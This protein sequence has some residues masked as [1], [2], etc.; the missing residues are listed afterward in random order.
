MTKPKQLLVCGILLICSVTAMAN[1]DSLFTMSE[2][3]AFDAWQHYAD[4][5]NATFEW[6]TGTVD[7]LDGIATLEV[8]EGFQYLN[9]EQS[10]FVMSELWGNPPEPSAGLL[11]LEGHKPLDT[12]VGYVVEITWA[13]EGYVSDEDAEELDFDD[14]MEQMQEDAAEINE[15]RVSMGYAAVDIIGWASEPMCDGETHRIHWAK[16]LNFE[17]EEANTMNYNIRVLGRRGYLMLN[18][19][20]GMEEL[21]SSRQMPRRS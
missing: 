8:P 6:Q 4:S 15:Q 1:T 11:F 2:E 12:L 10:E 7:L 9:G 3:E 16:E 21:R 19:I 18:A 20:G 5:V 13:E 17:G 14:L